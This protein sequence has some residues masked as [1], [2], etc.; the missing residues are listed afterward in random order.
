MRSAW[1]V[2]AGTFVS[3]MF[4]IGFFTY[5]VSILVPI[6]RDDFG[7][8]LE[9][10]MYSLA[11]GTFFGMFMLP[12]AGVLL[13]R[14]P[15]RWIMGGGTLACALGLW[16][17]S[18]VTSIT[19]YIL[20]FGLSMA[21]ANGF[22]GAISSQT[23]VSRWFTLTR[24]RALGVSAVGTSV[25]GILIP[26]LVTYWVSESGWR[27]T[28]QNLSL[29]IALGV[30]PFVLLTVRD[31][32]DEKAQ[33]SLRANT[34]GPATT[35]TV[36]LNTA[37]SL[38]EI[39]R[40]PNFW[41]LGIAL[42]VI[43]SVYSATLS[44]LAAYAISLDVPA[45]KAS[46]LIMV[47]ATMGI[48]GKLA[49]GFAA[50]KVNLKLGLLGAMVLICIGLGLL[51]TQPHYPIIFVA[52]ISLGLAAGGM[53]PIWGAIMAKVFGLLSYGRAMGAMGPLITLLVI[54]GYALMGRL[55]DI[56]GN[57]QLGLSI[58][59]GTVILASLLLIPLKIPR[60]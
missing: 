26:V 51:V 23:A 46:S 22:A 16:V 28:M 11:A 47:V 54:P 37:L 30:F 10:V 57:Y 14:Y 53:L 58:F 50:D 9:Q 32:P 52:C 42:G 7:V 39:I 34:D 55:F 31:K 41:C 24:G 17:L 19:Q 12:I 6:I 2:V 1:L 38:K 43:F 15:I 13:D 27:V 5:S 44:N 35:D 29:V 40:D 33:A 8:G 25:G 60:G 56:N 21:I 36:E 20:V 59:C 48:V 4:V 49:F 45:A 3:Q 18:G